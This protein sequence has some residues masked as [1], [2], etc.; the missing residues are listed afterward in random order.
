MIILDKPGIIKIPKHISTNISNKVL[1]LVYNLTKQVT[2][3]ETTIIEKDFFWELNIDSELITG[4]YTYM[5]YADD[6]LLEEGI[7]FYGEIN[8]TEHKQYKTENEVY[9]YE[10]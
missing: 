3:I 10:K 8:N 5:L 6:Y 9:I 7:L 4:E 1:K 2:V